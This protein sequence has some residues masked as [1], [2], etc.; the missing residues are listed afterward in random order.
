M[1]KTISNVRKY[2]NSRKSNMSK[3]HDCVSGSLK[4]KEKK[5]TYPFTKILK[6]G[7]GNNKNKS[8]H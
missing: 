3:Q 2:G 7:A 1:K 6:R 8:F 4:K 5:N